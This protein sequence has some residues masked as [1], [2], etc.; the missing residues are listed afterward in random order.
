MIFIDSEPLYT[1]KIRENKKENKVFPE[2][3]PPAV[4][5]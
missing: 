3:S 4:A 2:V 1:K 5:C